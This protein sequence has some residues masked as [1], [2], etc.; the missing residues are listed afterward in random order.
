MGEIFAGTLGETRGGADSTGISLTTT[1]VFRP[2]PPSA[3]HLAMTAREFTTADVV[4][5]ALNPYLV[6]FKTTDGLVAAANQTDY[7]EAAQDGSASTDVVLSSLDTA[8]NLDFLYV[9]AHR[10][11]RGVSIDVDAANGNASV[12]TVNYWNGSSWADISATDGTINTGAT[13]GQDGNVT[14]TVPAAWT[15]ERL[16]TAVTGS[17]SMPYT[18]MSLYWTRWQVSAALDASTTLNAMLSMAAS[19]N[20]A[21]LITGQSFETMVN[22]SPNRGIG[23]IEALTDAGTAFLTTIFSTARG[24]NF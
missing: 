10:P 3:R 13:M 23:S 14:W 16:I 2:I 8:A 12:L 4:K 9:G 20:Y 22:R 18:G 1:A 5:F 19:T 6:V 15:P 7:S 17:T 11:F 21:E 24:G